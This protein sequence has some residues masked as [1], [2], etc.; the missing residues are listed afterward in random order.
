ME[1]GEIAARARA[2]VGVRFR[3]QGRTR[4]QGL[5]CLGLAALALGVPA[6]TDY[7]LSSSELPALER[8]LRACGLREIEAAGAGEGDLL[9]LSP[10]LGRLHAA[11]LTAEGFV[12]ADARLRRVVEAPGAVPWRVRSAWRKCEEEID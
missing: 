1:G 8:E 2:L 4:E 7:R 5:D 3:P 12:H 6:R 9:V 10:A 11:I